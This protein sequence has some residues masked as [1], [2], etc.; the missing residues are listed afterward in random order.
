[1]CWKRDKKN[2]SILT[3]EK[4]YHRKICSYLD[5]QAPQLYG[6]SKTWLFGGRGSTLSRVVPHL[7]PNMAA[8]WAFCFELQ[9]FLCPTLSS[10]LPCC[11]VIKK[12]LQTLDFFHPWFNQSY[13][14][15]MERAGYKC[16]SGLKWWKPGGTCT[17]WEGNH[18]HK[19]LTAIP[20]ITEGEVARGQDTGRGVNTQTTMSLGKK[21]QISL[22]L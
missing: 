19:P 14:A 16:Q 10:S 21:N 13:W 3:W 20:T 18:Q 17:R 22:F 4:G 9:V 11:Q 8:V 2:K 5:S 7:H 6:Y 1:M 12:V 15:M